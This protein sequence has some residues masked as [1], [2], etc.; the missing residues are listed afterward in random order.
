MPTYVA[1]GNKPYLITPLE[2]YGIVVY[3]YS[4][5]KKTR[6]GGRYWRK[7]GSIP[8][9]VT[10]QSTFSRRPHERRNLAVKLFGAK[11]RRRAVIFGRSKGQCKP[12]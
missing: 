12:V 2:R 4:V 5:V 1:D 8:P 10:Y 3:N 6:D 11:I 9:T 7:T